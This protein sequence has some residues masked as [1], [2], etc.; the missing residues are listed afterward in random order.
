MGTI[1]HTLLALALCGLS[2]VASADTLTLKDGQTLTG[3]LVSRNSNGVVFEVAG[4]QMKLDSANVQSISFDDTPA[5]PAAAPV[6][7]PVPSAPANAI[8]LD[9]APV[10]SAPAQSAAKAAPTP[11]KT[12]PT[13]NNQ[14]VVVPAGTRIV[15]RTGEAIDSKKHSTGHK[16]TAR[17]EADLVVNNALVATRGTTVYGQVTEAKKSGNLAGKGSLQ[18]TFTDIMINNQM[19]PIITSGVKAVTTSTGGK[20]A[21]TTARAAAIGGLYNGSKGAKD[22]AKVGLGLSILTSGN[23]VNVPSG[24]LL[25]FNLQQ[26]LQL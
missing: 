9:T 21:G 5:T 20:T 15:V 2:A 24:T 13:T 4:Q 3:T 8:A 23:N 17:L 22:G 11:S 12:E 6:S 26:P 7:N 16:F 1:N 10:Q 19:K 25:E 18:F 14:T